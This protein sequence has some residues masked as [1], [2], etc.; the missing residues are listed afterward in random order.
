MRDGPFLLIRG[1]LLRAAELAR[2]A[3]REGEHGS[4]D[5]GR[6]KCQAQEVGLL[7]WVGSR[8]WNWTP[9]AGTPSK[10]KRSHMVKWIRNRFE[11]LI[12]GHERLIRWLW[13]FLTGCLVLYIILE[14]LGLWRWD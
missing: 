14:E 3:S 10:C 7:G 11:R 12:E 9:W 5:H 8:H 6:R 1:N 2:P 13:I 4:V